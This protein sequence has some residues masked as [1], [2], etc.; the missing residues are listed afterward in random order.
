MY[1]Y[2]IFLKPDGKDGF[3]HAGSLDA[4]D[5]EMALLYARETYCRRGEGALAWVVRRSSILVVDPVDLA[6]AARRS[7]GVND[8][9]VVAARRR[10]KRA[11]AASAPSQPVRPDDR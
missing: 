9:T 4:P 5:D 2:E 6:V 3:S 8:G 10:T 7:Q 1:T 11:G